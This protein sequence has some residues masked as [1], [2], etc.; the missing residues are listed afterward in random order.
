[1]DGLR[2]RVGEHAGTHLQQGARVRD[3]QILPIG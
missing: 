1:M 2:Q 3:I